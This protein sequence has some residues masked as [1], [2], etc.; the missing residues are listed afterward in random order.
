MYGMPAAGAVG[1]VIS[2]GREFENIT[3]SPAQ[4]YAIATAKDDHSTV[5]LLATGSISAIAGA[6]SNASR[7]V[8]SPQ[9]ASAALW[10]AQSSHFQILSGLRGA[11]TAREIDVTAFGEPIC[12]PGSDRRACAGTRVFLRAD[13]SGD[14]DGDPRDF[15]RQRSG[16]G[17][18]SAGRAACATAP[19]NA[20]RD[21][22]VE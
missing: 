15:G 10:L 12:E 18:V 21:R 16:L 4:N 5:L 20:R 11:A 13:G 19:R 17:F 9:G 14:R 7:I 6:A 3:I 22:C 8:V 2:G 1:A